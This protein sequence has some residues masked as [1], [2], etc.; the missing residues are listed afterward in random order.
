[1]NSDYF[2]AIT[3][4]SGGEELCDN[5]DATQ[6]QYCFGRQVK[7]LS[8]REGLYIENSS[9][10]PSYNNCKAFATEELKRRM[11]DLRTCIQ[12]FSRYDP[13]KIPLSE[14]ESIRKRKNCV[15]KARGDR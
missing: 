12:E 1:M 13:N 15:T 8:D 2:N 14:S 4:T 11:E 3:I 7:I 10:D 6:K 5:V 9:L